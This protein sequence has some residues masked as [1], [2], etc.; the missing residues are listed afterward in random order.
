[1]STANRRTPQEPKSEF[2][3]Y[4]RYWVSIAGAIC[5]LVAVLPLGAA[6]TVPDLV[7][8]WPRN[9]WVVA[10]GGCIGTIAL[11]FVAYRPRRPENVRKYAFRWILAGVISGALFVVAIASLGFEH[12]GERFLRGPW[13]TA[14]AESV[15]ASG[16]VNN[17]LG[18]LLVAFGYKSERRIW[19][20]HGIA[21]SVVFFAFCCFFWL[22]VGGTSLLVLEQYLRERR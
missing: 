22:I 14:E 7:P 2:V 5:A 9:S 13:L 8:T 17:D 10:I 12:D 15:I 11:C 6:K 1:M 3:E 21:K 20:Y 19:A 18:S 4:L 16:T